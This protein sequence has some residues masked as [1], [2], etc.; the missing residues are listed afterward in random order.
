MKASEMQQRGGATLKFVLAIPLVLILACVTWYVLS[1][2][3][4]RYWDRRVVE[5]CAKEGGVEIFQHVELT[6]EQFRTLPKVDGH[7]TGNASMNLTLESEPTYAESKIEVVR[8]NSPRVW[9]T[10]SLIRRKSDAEAVARYVRVSRLGGD[11]ITVDHPSSFMC[12]P[13][14]QIYADLSKIF[15]KK[16]IQ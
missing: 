12:P 1:D 9:K 11:P 6:E 10:T 13:S 15:I 8:E 16:V 2:Q 4:Q 7:V 3:W 5:L 14:E